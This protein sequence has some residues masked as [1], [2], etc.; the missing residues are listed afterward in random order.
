MNPSGKYEGTKALNKAFLSRFPIIIQLSFPTPATEREIVKIYSK[1]KPAVAFNLVKLAGDLRASYKKDEIEY[2]CSTRDLI[3]CAKLSEKLGL[4]RA[5]QL[6]IL[7]RCSE[8][9]IKAV[10]TAVSLYF[11]KLGK[12]LKQINYEEKYEKEKTRLLD[13]ARNVERYLA[14]LQTT[15]YAK[16]LR[17]KIARARKDVRENL[18]KLERE[19]DSGI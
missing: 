11:G 7:N 1:V 3:N 14:D 6:A 12:P 18:V 10:S 19:H 9:D 15:P 16:D 8:E 4:K 5:L 2:V 13:H 17:K